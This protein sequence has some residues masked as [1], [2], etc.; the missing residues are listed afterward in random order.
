MLSF[1]FQCSLLM[2]TLSSCLSR[3][4]SWFIFAAEW[5]ILFFSPSYYYSILWAFPNREWSFIG[6]KRSGWFIVWHLTF[7]FFLRNLNNNQ[8]WFFNFQWISSALPPPP[9]RFRFT[10]I[11]SRL[12]DLKNFSGSHQET[13][14]EKSISC[15]QLC[16]PV[17]GSDTTRQVLESGIGGTLRNSVRQLC[18]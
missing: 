3:L 6:R 8:F 2:R 12:Q 16:S 15:Q 1:S 5:P 7:Q 14:I 4:P 10:T 18:K 9:S 11:Q 13:F 17:M